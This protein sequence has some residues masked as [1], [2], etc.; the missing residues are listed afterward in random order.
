[1]LVEVIIWGFFIGGI[2]YYAMKR[3]EDK[4]HEN[5]EERDN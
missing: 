4:K 5:F 3:F 1:M 2:V